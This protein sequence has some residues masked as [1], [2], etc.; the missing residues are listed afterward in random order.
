MQAG[1]YYGFV[2]Q[3]D[4]L[5]ARM[6]K[7][8]GGMAKVVATGGLAVVISPATKSIDVVEPMLTLE[9]LRIIYERNC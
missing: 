2:G 6:R 8:L 1:V 3:V 5:V 9:G 4:G 7:E